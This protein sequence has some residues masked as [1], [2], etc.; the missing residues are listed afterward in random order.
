M[1]GLVIKGD[2]Q[3]AHKAAEQRDIKATFVGVASQYGYVILQAEERDYFK[4]ALWFREPGQ[5]PYPTGAL[6]HYCFRSAH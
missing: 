4:I 1:I 3:A 5:A 6:L 2:T